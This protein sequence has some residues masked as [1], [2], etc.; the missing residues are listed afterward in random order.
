ML[1][2]VGVDRPTDAQPS[3]ARRAWTVY[4]DGECPVCR[5]E[6]AFYRRIDTNG[7]VAWQDITSLGENELPFGKNREDLLGV[8]H[9]RNSENDW[10][11]GVDAFA[12]IWSQLPMFRWFAWVFR[13]PILRLLAKACYQLFLT[14]QRRDRARRQGRS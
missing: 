6:V 8:F 5:M 1:D 13:V 9:A 12:A 10:E 2:L 11:T 4:Y 3:R 7:H 14:W